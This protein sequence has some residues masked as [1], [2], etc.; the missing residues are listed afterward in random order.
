LVV[1]EKAQRVANFHEETIHSFLEMIAAAGLNSHEEIERK[2]VNRR[3]GMHSIAKYNE[4]YP[5]IE[6]GVYLK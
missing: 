5:P 6:K 1:D 4:I 2:H 3:V